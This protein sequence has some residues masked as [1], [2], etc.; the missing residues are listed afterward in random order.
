[1]TWHFVPLGPIF[2]HPP[3]VAATILQGKFYVNLVE[4]FP[5]KKPKTFISTYLCPIWGKNM[6]NNGY[7]SQKPERTHNMP[8]N[9]VTWSHN[10]N[11]LRKLIKAPEI[12]FWRFWTIKNWLKNVKQKSTC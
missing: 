3:K 1:M 10:K 12:Q 6:A 8:V 11:F 2:Y 5:E 9:Q 7:F 4:T